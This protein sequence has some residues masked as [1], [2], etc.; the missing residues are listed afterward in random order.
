MSLFCCSLYAVLDKKLTCLFLSC[1]VSNSKPVILSCWAQICSKN[2]QHGP[3]TVKC[4]VE[5]SALSAFGK[6]NWLQVFSTVFNKRVS[7]QSCPTLCDPRDCSRQAPLSLG[8]SRQEYWSGLPFPFQGYLLNPGI[9]PK[10]PVS[11]ALILYPLFKLTQIMVCYSPCFPFWNFT[12][13]LFIYIYIYI[14]IYTHTHTYSF[15]YSF[16]I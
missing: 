12:V 4:R 2:S 10:S 6:H 3:Y 16:P 13:N 5:G 1:H 11:P 9:E 15:S 8:F 7:A 14:Y